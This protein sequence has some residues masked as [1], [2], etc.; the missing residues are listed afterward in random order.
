[1]EVV[2]EAVAEWECRSRSRLEKQRQKQ[3]VKAEAKQFVEV[4]AKAETDWECRSKAKGGSKATK[5]TAISRVLSVQSM[6]SQAVLTNYTL[7][8][9][10]LT[11]PSNSTL[12]RL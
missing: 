7:K 12:K 3:T 5:P 11:V 4:V 1:M 2:A 10:L 8:L 9:Y 6:Y